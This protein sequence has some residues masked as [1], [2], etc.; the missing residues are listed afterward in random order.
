MQHWVMPPKPTK[1][2]SPEQLDQMARTWQ[3]K[4]RSDHCRLRYCFWCSECE[5]HVECSDPFDGSTWI[6]CSNCDRLTQP[7][8]G[9][10][11]FMLIFPEDSVPYAIDVDQDF[12][13]SS[14]EGLRLSRRRPLKAALQ[15]E[16][17]VAPL[18][19]WVAVM[20]TVINSHE[21]KD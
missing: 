2:H 18:K 19:D 8:E 7:N 17:Q 21:E 11:R 4:Y 6:T 20:E 9:W 5:G 13:L 1:L 15:A 12:L 3:R 16:G 10:L 14:E